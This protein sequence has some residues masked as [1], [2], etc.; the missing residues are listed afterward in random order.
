MTELITSLLLGFAAAKLWPVVWPGVVRAWC[1]TLER[2]P[3]AE[4]LCDCG[5]GEFSVEIGDKIGEACGDAVNAECHVAP[6]DTKE[7][8]C[9]LY[10]RGHTY[11]LRFRKADTRLALAML[12]RWAA[13]PRLNFD[14]HAAHIARQFIETHTPPTPHPTGNA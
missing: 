13:D 5:Q 12:D 4:P 10:S 8:T 14:A 9:W 3:P 6:Y 2:N 1:T 11:L 7:R